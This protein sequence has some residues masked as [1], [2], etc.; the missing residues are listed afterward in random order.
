MM[1]T[2]QRDA[3]RERNHRRAVAC[4][5]C[6]SMNTREVYGKDLPSDSHFPDVLY[7]VCGACGFDD[8]KRRGR[9]R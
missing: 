3:L 7:K 4:G 1:T 9:R 6:G 8:V 2:E 5:R